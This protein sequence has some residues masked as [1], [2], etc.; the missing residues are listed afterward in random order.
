MAQNSVE[1]EAV[2]LHFRGVT[3]GINREVDSMA[4]MGLQ[5]QHDIDV[6]EKVFANAPNILMLC[7]TAIGLIKIYTRFER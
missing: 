1:C 3:N 5:Q 6:S 4:N 7:L 2:A